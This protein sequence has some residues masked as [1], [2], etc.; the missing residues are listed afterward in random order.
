MEHLFISAQKDFAWHRPY[1]QQRRTRIL[2]VFQ[3]ETR[4]I[5]QVSWYM[6]LSRI[7]HVGGPL[8]ENF[9]IEAIVDRCALFKFCRTLHGLKQFCPR[10]AI[11]TWWNGKWNT[12]KWGLMCQKYV[13]RAMKRNYNPQCLWGIITCPCPT[14]ML[15]GTHVLNLIVIKQTKKQ[16]NN[17]MAKNVP[18]FLDKIAHVTIIYEFLSVFSKF[19]WVL[20]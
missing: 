20:S 18:C 4:V 1:Y 16:T 7:M 6:V 5:W 17:H 15:F 9:A 10:Y 19:V 14:Y 3:L 11:F 12:D 2:F 8:P 13:S